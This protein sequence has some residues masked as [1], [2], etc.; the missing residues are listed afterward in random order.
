MTPDAGPTFLVLGHEDIEGGLWMF[1]WIAPLILPPLAIFRAFR[2]HHPRWPFFPYDN[3]F[4][5]G[6]L[7]L[8]WSNQELF[9]IELDYVHVHWERVLVELH[10]QAFCKF[11]LSFIYG[12]LNLSMENIA[13]ISSMRIKIMPFT[14]SMLF[15]LLR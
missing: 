2:F 3:L 13:I 9:P 11:Q 14:I 15:E 8:R 10:L 5:L 6:R 1:L 4:A 12:R 7:G